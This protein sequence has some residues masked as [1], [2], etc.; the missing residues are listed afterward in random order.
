MAIKGL[1]YF[2]LD[3][4]NDDQ[5]SSLLQFGLLKWRSKFFSTPFWSCWNGNQRSSI[6]QS[7]VVVMAI[8]GLPYFNLECWNGNQ[9]FSSSIWTVEMAIKGLLY[10]DPDCWNFDQRSFLLWYGVVGVLIQGFSTSIWSLLKCRSRASLLRSEVLPA[11]S[12]N[13]GTRLLNYESFLIPLFF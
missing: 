4:W 5:R 13:L 3:Y 9:R 8:K 6:L 12:Q 2:N 11:K 10:F 1:L 7:G